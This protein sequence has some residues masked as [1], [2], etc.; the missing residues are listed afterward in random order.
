MYFWTPVREKPPSDAPNTPILH[1]EE[2]SLLPRKY[3]ANS[4]V[5]MKQLTPA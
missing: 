3:F 1:T 5:Q 4:F 2:G